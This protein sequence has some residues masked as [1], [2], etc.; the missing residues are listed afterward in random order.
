MNYAPEMIGIGR[1]MSDLAAGLVGRGISVEVISPPPHYPDW[2]VRLPYSA[3]RYRS[4]QLAGV[5]V[6]RCPIALRRGA[7]GIWRLVS[8]LTFGITSLPV[9]LWRSLASRPSA[10]VCLQPTLFVAPAV[11]LAAWL[12]GARAVLYTQDLEVDAAFATGHLPSSGRARR[13]A[14]WFERMLLR[15]FDSVVTIS[16]R[17]AARLRQKGVVAERLTV[18][19]N[20]VD[21]TR[22]YPLARPSAYRSM[23][24]ISAD[25]YVVL[26]A[27]HLGIKQGL[28]VALEAARQLQARPDI[29]FVIAGE[30]PSKQALVER[31]G[32]QANVRFLPLQPEDRLNELLNLADCHI[33]PQEPSVQ[34]L[35]LPSKLGGM[36][37]SGKQCLVMADSGSELADFLGDCCVIVAPQDHAQL[38]EIIARLA[39]N[40]QTDTGSS[41]RLQRAST[42]SPPN[43]LDAFVHVLQA[44]TGG[45]V[46][47]ESVA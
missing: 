47:R 1:Y 40:R 25:D 16:N 34:D 42:L 22:I 30:G 26:Y 37:A 6:I 18:V 3:A 39:D 45:D 5:K 29:V 23:L 36:L 44:D 11:I 24:G 14:F 10:I 35:V 2:Y 4:E 13:L 33:L 12:T 32:G 46:G 27:G 19:R 38:P 20:W 41:A 15:G 8:P 9:I 43:A 28:P 31:Y 7:K 21:A 17:M